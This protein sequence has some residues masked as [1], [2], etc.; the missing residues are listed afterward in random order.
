M[1]SDSYNNTESA[2]TVHRVVSWL[3]TKMQR[4]LIFRDAVFM[5]M[6]ELDANSNRGPEDII[7]LINAEKPQKSK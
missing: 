2:K 1:L 6:D 7:I 4:L 5:G 3:P